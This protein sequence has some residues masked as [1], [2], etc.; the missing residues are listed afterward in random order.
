MSRYIVLNDSKFIGFAASE[1]RTLFKECN[2]TVRVD[3]LHGIIFIETEKPA[4]GLYNGIVKKSI[5]VN[6]IIE[7]YSETDAHECK[8]LA[9]KIY[10]T[11]IIKKDKSFKI[12]VRKLG[13]HMEGSAK[14]I[15]VCIG[16]ELEMKGLHAD[17]KA[18]NIAIGIILVGSS[19]YIGVLEPDVHLD[20]FRM[21]ANTNMLN[22][23]EFKLAEIF[24][25][26]G[27]S[28]MA[29]NGGKALDIGSAPGGWADFM[30]SKGLHVVAVDSALLQYSTLAKRGSMMVVSQSAVKCDECVQ[31]VTGSEATIAD[32]SKI[33][34]EAMH[35]N[36]VH[37]KMGLCKESIN[38]INALGPFSLLTVDSNTSPKESADFVAS[39]LPH[40]QGNAYI[41]MTLKLV[42]YD[43]N[44]HIN[45]VKRVLGTA[46]SY[47]QFKKLPHNRRELSMLAKLKQ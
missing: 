28:T 45:D 31:Y 10:N 32:I 25:F 14:D 18:P 9:D 20:Y 35:Y 1:L 24:E 5:F 26:F 46:C 11:G 6:S 39:L 19:A 27:L 47:M 7:V 8:E 2:A 41:I 44:K 30:L 23:S 40:M 34:N 43:I 22:R 17:L 36:I 37:I 38:I 29:S 13:A 4:G 16:S 42:D 3:E 15:E 21:N 33:A 12:E